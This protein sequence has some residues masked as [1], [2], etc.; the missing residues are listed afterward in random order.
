MRTVTL[1]ALVITFG[2]AY[3]TLPSTPG[4]DLEKLP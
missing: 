1:G 2:V 3:A 4:V